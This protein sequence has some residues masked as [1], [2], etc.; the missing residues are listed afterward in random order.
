MASKKEQALALYKT[1]SEA[2]ADGSVVRKTFID[3]CVAELGMTPAGASTY[4]SNS[5]TAASGGAV[6]SY[7]VPSA[8]KA[9]TQAVDDSKA[10]APL[11]SVVVVDGDVV[12]S[13]HAF[14]NPAAA[15]NRWNSLKPAT[16]ARCLVVV[17]DPKEG[18]AVSNLTLLD[19]ATVATS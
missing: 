3:R 8:D 18:E 17:G 4:Y 13:T 5:K 1:M 2:S 10:N 15:A 12:S 11:W 7:Y 6:K 16:Q 9:V 19:T 14:M